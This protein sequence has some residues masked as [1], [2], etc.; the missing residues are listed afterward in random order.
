[1]KR[2]LTWSGIIITA[3]ILQS[4]FFAVFAY[5]GIKPDLLLIIVISS[6]LL[7]GKDHGVVTGFFAGL[8]QDLSTGTFFG[9]NTFSKMLLGYGFGIAEEHVFKENALLPVVA[10]L[11][12]SFVNTLMTIIFML[13]LGHKVELSNAIISVLCPVLIYNLIMAFPIYK[14]VNKIGTWLKA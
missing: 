6:A 4:T 9:V 7:Y 3:L 13:L 11:M 2:F 12:G 1:M 8:L 5:N 14:L 10:I